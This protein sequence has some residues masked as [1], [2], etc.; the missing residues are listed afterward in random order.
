MPRKSARRKPRPRKRKKKSA[1]VPALV[2]MSA[3][4]AAVV[5][6]GVL[7]SRDATPS[8]ED[9]G[10]GLPAPDVAEIGAGGDAEIV[11]KDK[12]DRDRT[13]AVIAFDS[14][15]PVGQG[16]Y[17]TVNPQ[18]WVYLDDGS[19]LHVR[20]D[21]GRFYAPDEQ[22]PQSGVMRGNVVIRLFDPAPQRP[23]DDA[24]AP[25]IARLDVLDFDTEYGAVTTNSPGL[26]ITPEFEF[27]FNDLR[28]V[29]N[30]VQER[31]ELL[32][33][34]QGGR[35]TYTPLPSPTPTPDSA[36]RG[37]GRQDNRALAPAQMIATSLRQPAIPAA[38]SGSQTGSPSGAQ[39]G[40]QPATPPTT[41][42]PPT[43]VHYLAHFRDAVKI[44]QDAVTATGDSL[45]V[46]ARVVDNKL[47]EGAV[48]SP[49]VRTGDWSHGA[50]AA[51]TPATQIRGALA[52]MVVASSESRW[53]PRR[54]FNAAPASPI[55]SPEPGTPALLGEVQIQPLDR[56]VESPAPESAPAPPDGGSEF[57][58]R[59]ARDVATNLPVTLA[60]SGP[61]T[62]RPLAAEPMEL[63]RDHLVARLTGGEGGGVNLADGAS[64]ATGVCTRLDYAFTT[65]S[66]V[67]AGVGDTGVRLSAASRPDPLIPTAISRE[68]ERT[69]DA[70][71][72]DT[73]LGDA[74]P[75]DN[76]PSGVLRA[77]R[78]EYSIATG[79]G[80]VPGPGTLEGQA[81]QRIGWNR[82]MD[83]VLRSEGDRVLSEL[84]EVIFQ[85]DVHGE[86]DTASFDADYA[87]AE[88]VL[89]PDRR[90]AISA[91]TLEDSVSLRGRED[92]RVTADSARVEFAPD[93]TPEPQAHEPAERDLAPSPGS[94]PIPSFF[95]ADGGVLAVRPGERLAASH[96][97]ATLGP[98]A[99]GRPS[100]HTLSANGTVDLRARRDDIAI[101]GDD[102]EVDLPSQRLWVRGVP[103]T[104]ARVAR[105]PT[106]IT[107]LDV[108][109]GGQ[110]RSASI[111]GV[112]TFSHTAGGDADS[113]RPFATEANQG[114]TTTFDAAWSQTM[115]F[116][117]RAGTLRCVGDVDATM[118]RGDARVDRL[119]AWTV[120]ATFDPSSQPTPQ[121][122]PGVTGALDLTATGTDLGT[123]PAADAGADPQPQ[124]GAIVS[125]DH[126]PPDE[127]LIAPVDEQDQNRRVLSV[128]ATGS[129]IDS[130]DGE[131]AT[132]ESRRYAPTAADGSRVL[133]QLHYLQGP[134]I[135]ADN[136]AGTLDVPG[137]GKL[138]VVDRRTPD[139]QR[140]AVASPPASPP[141]SPDPSPFAGATARG[142]ALFD[143]Q[144]SLTAQRTD[145]GS[146]MTM[147][148]RV[149]MTHRRNGDD[150]ITSL[151]A[152]VLIART[153]GAAQ[154][155]GER[156]QGVHA[157]GGVWVRSG[158]KEVTADIVDYDAE[159]GILTA[160]ASLGNQVRVMDGPN[161]W[162]ASAI[163]WD[164]ISGRIEIAAPGGVVAPR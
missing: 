155:Q 106:V 87:R 107:G 141:T 61:L 112:G 45:E 119:Q 104:L 51:S 69:A 158:D 128:I 124:P 10:L 68:P 16:R 13:V 92:E 66:L 2:L 98:G 44:T 163:R 58:S 131:S 4:G 81:F 125:A 21:E 78:A 74:P 160:V 146:S 23:A 123:E 145:A 144:G 57:R 65:R 31:I 32:E 85:G 49:S 64:G 36:W 8:P 122:N 110:P 136:A 120:E 88:F 27:A 95:K 76:A 93:S 148:D 96:V 126:E 67:L 154:G 35:I 134:R 34:R 15:T 54:M 3:A 59:P 20:A 162:T 39:P 60:W 114:D 56:V 79:I 109:L 138:M 132:I 55:A 101:T 14:Q 102:L 115:T 142:D 75:G 11:L 137:A 6:A 121:A 19:Y 133:L 161:I 127:F 100:L 33:V 63:R 139:E 130:P 84:E 77:G 164:M 38:G 9:S 17:D 22:R 53:P 24:V 151:D 118:K 153:G 140:P 97:E 152:P 29:M 99:D 116:D 117:D 7:F 89:T 40:A 94:D 149:R 71:S 50:I 113:G 43:P 1:L 46:W 18:A 103:G 105:G 80:R 42:P 28:L 150:L 47:P 143:W 41:P 25:I 159:T 70:P 156:V 5:A 12:D 91:I 52:S 157:E 108:R 82:Q 129:I 72:G 37:G 147:T 26:V 83:F 62:L 30:Q 48:V 86:D 135:I 111:Y 90:S 73:T